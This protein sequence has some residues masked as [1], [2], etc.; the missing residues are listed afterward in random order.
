MWVGLEEG[1][2]FLMPVLGSFV[3][4]LTEPLAPRCRHLSPPFSAPFLSSWWGAGTKGLPERR[5]RPA[6]P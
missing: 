1:P 3:A 6:S 2:G 5:I 4:L